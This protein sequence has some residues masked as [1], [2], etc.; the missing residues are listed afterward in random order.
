MYYYTIYTMLLYPVSEIVPFLFRDDCFFTPDI[1]L[2]HL[3]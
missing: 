3:P 1:V 2:Y